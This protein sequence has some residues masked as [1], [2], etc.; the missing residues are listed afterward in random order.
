MCES[1]HVAINTYINYCFVHVFK[2]Y[3]LIVVL[4]AAVTIAYHLS[5]VKCFYA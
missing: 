2:Y 5:D 1:L 4:T 3:F